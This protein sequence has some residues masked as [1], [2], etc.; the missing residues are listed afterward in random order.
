MRHTSRRDFLKHSTAALVAPWFFTRSAFGDP[1]HS[2]PSE[3]ITL[4]LIGLKK[5]GGAH[6]ET[7]LKR[8]D[9]QI[10]ALCD[11]DESARTAALTKVEEA[12]GAKQRDGKYAGCDAYNEYERVLA[13]PD[14]DAVLIA[15]PDH[16]HALI[17][18]AACRAGKDVYCEKPLSLTIREARAMVAAARR[19]GR[20]FQTGTQQRSAPEFRKACELVRSGYIGDIKTVHVECG[21][22]SQ[23]MEYEPEPVPPGFD[24]ERWLGP[25][26]L[27]PFNSLR[28]G[29]DYNNGWRRIRDYSGGKMTDWGAHH[30]DIV[31]WG[32]GMDG[33]GPIEIIPPQVDAAKAEKWQA[34]RRER[35]LD[36][37]AARPEDPSWG[38]RYVYPGGI[39]V[40]KDGT[41][42]VLFEGT[43]GKI[44]V[45][46]EHLR[47]WPQS[48]RVQTIG[49]NDVHLEESPGHHDNWFACI[50]S[51]RRPI[52]DVET[53]CRSVTVCHLGNIALWLGRAIR[54]DA[55]SE[56]IVGDEQAAA[57]LDR[58]KRAPYA[59]SAWHLVR[60]EQSSALSLENEA[61]LGCLGGSGGALP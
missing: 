18:I 54:W 51:R 7:L 25:A 28:V 31:Q 9:V 24:Y 43:N 5:M 50:R 41:N 45:N 38:L 39:E 17:A 35:K 23:P 42:G 1:K 37:A 57:W 44:E 29:S 47:T 15:V 49:A 60:R 53:A 52:S 48:L 21:E 46:R 22:P 10:L 61:P 59:P 2:A 36:G 3:R 16:W 58:P 19:Y 40:I 8:D 12:Y 27:A 4:G 20:V 34:G 6:L 14:I 30:F 33:A 55:A 13:R 32:L 56:Q 11:V 26:P